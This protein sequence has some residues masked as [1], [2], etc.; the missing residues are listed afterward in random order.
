VGDPDAL[1]GAAL[2]VA[3]ARGEEAGLLA[4]H[5]AYGS[6]LVGYAEFLLATRPAPEDAGHPADEAAAAVRDAL[7]VATGA[8]ADL[9]DPDRMRA[10][11]LAL[12]RN[13]CLRRRPGAGLPAP[14]EAAELGRRGLRP[15]DVAAL[16]GFAP[17]SVPVRQA[18][19]EVPP[20]WLRSELAAAAGPAGLAR[21]VELA[22]RARPFDPDGFPVPLDRRRL[23]TTVL[24]WSAAAAVVLALA[25]LVLLPT[26]GAGAGAAA[27]Q[28]PLLAAAAGS[29][30]PDPATTVP[31][32]PVPTLADAPFGVPTTTAAR[33]APAADR[34]GDRPTVAPTPAAPATPAR[35]AAAPQPRTQAETDGQSRRIGVTWSQAG[36][37]DGW[38]AAVHATT[39]GA[40]VG[41]VVA[42]GGGATTVL[43]RDGDGWSG[44]LTGL[45]TGR[46]VVVTV[47]ADGPLRP[48][49][50]TL[51][52]D[53]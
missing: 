37:G 7:L 47:F 1:A 52:A 32:E 38:T 9:A 46:T 10:W 28:G 51:R 17:A 24:A 49:S 20:A 14:V 6:D 29:S 39:G 12:T 22:R 48:G 34:G 25:L 8:A 3:L 53:C 31:D 35:T 16:V 27:P 50:S 23:P 2:A 21:R 33:P 4:A 18:A 40:D 45:P 5:D 30:S 15:A 26:G 36:C 43:R 42:V 44:E 41:R 11:L 13:E 19:P